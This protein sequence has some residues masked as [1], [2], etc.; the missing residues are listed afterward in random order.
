MI[1]AIPIGAALC[2]SRRKP[3]RSNTRT[4]R[5]RITI[6]RPSPTYWTA[7]VRLLQADDVSEGEDEELDS[8]EG[9]FRTVSLG[10][11]TFEPVKL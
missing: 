8:V 7:K 9:T 10:L 11:K 3:H 6:R 5:T 4:A 1:R 2:S